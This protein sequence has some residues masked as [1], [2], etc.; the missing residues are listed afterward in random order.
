MFKPKRYM[1]V[2]YYSY[3]RYLPS[4]VLDY[5]CYLLQVRKHDVSVSPS[6]KVFLE[7]TLQC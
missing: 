7:V 2:I 4:E 5:T 3:N 6:I 1:K